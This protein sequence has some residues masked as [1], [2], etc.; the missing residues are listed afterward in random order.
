MRKKYTMKANVKSIILM[1]MIA[2]CQAAWADVEINEV[3]FPDEHFRYWILSEPY[4]KDGILTDKEIAEIKTLDIP[5]D[6]YIRSLSG[7]EHFTSLIHLICPDNILTS[8][9]LSKNTAL[10]YLTCCGNRLTKLDVSHNTELISIACFGN[11]LT[12]LDLSN[13]KK[14]KELWCMFNQIKGRAM[15]ELVNSLPNVMRTDSQVEKTFLL[16][17]YS[18]KNDHT[19]NVMTKDQVAAAKAKGWNPVCFGTN[20][21][22]TDYLGE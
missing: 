21:N 19:D 2:I 12:S 6:L 7:I 14:L 20:K 1:L 5:A 13:N 10:K 15:D 3:N 4:G 11:K 8:I 16:M 22:Y 18:S 17:R 9:D